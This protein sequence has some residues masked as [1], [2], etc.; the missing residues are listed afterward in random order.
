M[1]PCMQ[2]YTP[3]TF[4]KI[5]PATVTTCTLVH[6]DESL[7]LYYI[8]LYRRI[9]IVLVTIPA[10][11]W[12]GARAPASDK[13]SRSVSPGL[14]LK[15]PGYPITTKFESRQLIINHGHP[16]TSIVATVPCSVLFSSVLYLFV[17]V[18]KRRAWPSCLTFPSCHVFPLSSS[19]RFFDSHNVGRSLLEQ[20]FMA[21][22]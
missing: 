9:A 21:N 3:T 10:T 14:S 13:T 5:Y 12:G 7:A 6:V 2:F 18:L 22:H 11:G 15:Y 17:R 8:Q 16:S 4:N 1:R 20:R 19:L